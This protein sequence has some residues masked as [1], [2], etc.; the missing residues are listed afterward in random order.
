MQLTLY[1]RAF[2]RCIAGRSNPARIAMM[3]MTVSNS[4]KVNA[5]VVAK[6]L[7]R[8]P[9]GQIGGSGFPL[10]AG[11]D[12][13]QKPTQVWSVMQ[14]FQALNPAIFGHISHFLERGCSCAHVTQLSIPAERNVRTYEAMSL[15]G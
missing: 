4:I 5:P 6:G 1:E 12:I 8:H 7:S 11:I 2:A 15:S 3:A 14:K 9:P 13:W 10:R